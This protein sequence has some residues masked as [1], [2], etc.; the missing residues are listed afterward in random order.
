MGSGFSAGGG[1]T[2]P[3][4]PLLRCVQPG[5]SAAERRTSLGAGLVPLGPRD[6]RET[7]RAGT[8]NGGLAEERK[9]G[10][11]TEAQIPSSLPAGL[12]YGCPRI[13][14]HLPPFRPLRLGSNFSVP[15]TETGP[16]R[17]SRRSIEGGVGKASSRSY[18]GFRDSCAVFSNVVGRMSFYA[19]GQKCARTIRITERIEV[20]L[21]LLGTMNRWPKGRPEMMRW[22]RATKRSLIT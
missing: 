11:P 1:I 16:R 3:L 13:A 22:L 20:D 7:R 21:S 4:R 8:R 14:A 10:L 5:A 9:Q 19:V 2:D 6:G 18:K 12:Y 17:D 15:E